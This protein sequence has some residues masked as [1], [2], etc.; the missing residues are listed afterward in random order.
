MSSPLVQP[1]SLKTKKTQI[2]SSKDFRSQKKNLKFSNHLSTSSQEDT[3]LP[4][5][6]PLKYCIATIM[7][8]FTDAKICSM[9]LMNST[10]LVSDSEEETQL[11][12]KMPIDSLVEV[13]NTAI[14][15]LE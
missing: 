15:G 14:K 12:D 11:E 13:L 10:T 9:V 3:E 2:P 6:M 5:M 8:R 4:K 7:P 1:Y